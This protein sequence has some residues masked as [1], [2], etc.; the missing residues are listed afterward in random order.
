M[1]NQVDKILTFSLATV[2]LS[3]NLKMENANASKS[4]TLRVKNDVSI[5]VINNQVS[6]SQSFQLAKIKFKPKSD[7]SKNEQHGNSNNQESYE[8]DIKARKENLKTLPRVQRN[9]AAAALRNVIAA[10]GRKMRGVNHSQA[11]KH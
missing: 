10:Q 4:N 7:A 1:P 2:L 3:M 8:R 11:K 6:N 5:N 9:K